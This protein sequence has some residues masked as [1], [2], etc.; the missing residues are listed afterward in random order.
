MSENIITALPGES[1]FSIERAFEAPRRLVWKCY[2]EPQHLARFWGPRDA[3]TTSTIDLRVGGVWRTDWRYENGSEYGYSSVYL[4]LV[5]PERIHYRDAPKDWPG[6]LEGLPPAD[7]ISTISLAETDR[8]TTVTAHVD[9]LSVA[10]R[11]ETVRRGFTGMV[12]MGNDR[13]TEYLQTLTEGG[14]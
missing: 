8:V 1:W 10:Y 7:M 9:C 12:S 14:L 4:E 2:T 6:G 3:K 11:D 5:E 13:L